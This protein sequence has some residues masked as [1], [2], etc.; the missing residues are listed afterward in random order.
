M[1][2]ILSQ[3]TDLVMGAL[4]T[5]VILVF[6]YVFLRIVFFGPLQKLLKERH[7]AT[8]GRQKEAQKSIAAAEAKAA[9]YTAAFEQA[10]A[11]TLRAREAAREAALQA[12]A[13]LVEKTRA[14]AGERIKA[15][16]A[17]IESDVTTA[18]EQL[19][20]DSQQLAESITEAILR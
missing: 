18:R 19:G 1:D 12:R 17:V 2:K 5:M 20:R 7:D 8:E 16:L 14:T 15:G 10:R 9:D 13:A 6:L 4:P 11:A 3:L